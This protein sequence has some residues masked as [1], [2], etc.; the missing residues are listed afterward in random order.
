MI[1][2]Q[3]YSCGHLARHGARPALLWLPLSAEMNARHIFPAGIGIKDFVLYFSLLVVADRRD[4][5]QK[6]VSFGNR[7]VVFVILSAERSD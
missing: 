6:T 5:N 2:D 7:F 3:S 4:V 1:S